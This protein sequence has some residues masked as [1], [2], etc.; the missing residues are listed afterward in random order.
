M[1]T[2]IDLNAIAQSFTPII[3]QLNSL[4]TQTVGLEV[5]WMRAI[6]HEKSEDVI[7]HE[8][9]LHDVECP[10]VIKV[11]TSNSS[12]N[13][14]NFTIDYFGINYEAPLEV[15]VDTATWVSVFGQDTMPQ[16][17]DIVYI[18]LLN[19]L[20]EV[21]TSTV[22]Y[23]FMNQ[24]VGFKI[25]LTKWNPRAN[26]R[27]NQAVEDT[28]D[29]LTVG[30][31]ELFNDEISNQIA[32]IIDEPETSEL[33]NSSA[34][35]ND[36]FKTRDIDAIEMNSIET[37]QNHIANSYYD[38]RYMTQ[39]IIYRNGDLYDVT[40]KDNYRYFSCWFKIIKDEN[41]PIEIGS[42]ENKNGKYYLSANVN[43]LEDGGDVEFRRGNFL[44]M[45]AVTNQVR[46]AN[47]QLRYMVTFNN[48]EYRDVVKKITNW[49]SNLSMV[50]TKN[51]PLLMGRTGGKCNFSISVIGTNSIMVKF[52]TK[53]KRVA[54]GNIPQNQWVAIG[55]S[56]GKESKGYFFTKDAQWNLRLTSEFD[57]GNMEN[58]FEVGEFYIP[59]SDTLLTNIRYYR[60][61]EYSDEELVN[62]DLNWMLAKNDSRT[63]VNDNAAVPNTSPF[64]T[65]QR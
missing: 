49:N 5:H 18:E 64:I 17:H 52:G 25:Q 36:I 44:T 43:G 29:D 27:L 21:A 11:V 57:L 37:K 61:S 4:A 7:F 46:L 40:S 16:Q 8:Y 47:G 39:A 24:E 9:T 65:S 22:E 35:E 56:L 50:V 33:L 23:G 42:L 14:G 3:N 48:S 26:V 45:H 58:S 2:L 38:L 19:C 41:R 10:R 53:A 20:Y 15:S 51:H 31:A 59:Q 54:I 62:K 55:I 30:E 13:P 63:I 28:I 60:T 34:A 12:Y 32:D 1:G 6:P